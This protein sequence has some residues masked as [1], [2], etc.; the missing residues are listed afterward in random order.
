[1]TRLAYTVLVAAALAAPLAS[2]NRFVFDINSGASS[3]TFSGS[4]TLGPIQGNP[5][6]SFNPSGSIDLDL[7]TSGSTVTSGRFVSGATATVI[8]TLSA[9]VPN[10]ILPT[11]PPIATLTVTGA[12]VQFTSPS[13]SVTGGNFSTQVTATMLSGVASGSALGVPISIDLTG[14]QS[15]PAPISGTISHGANGFSLNVPLTGS[16]SFTEP[17]SGVGGTLTIAGTVVGD[18]AALSMDTATISLPS[19]GQQSLTLSAGSTH[20][21]GIYLVLG[22]GSGT[23]PGINLGGAT[24]PLN[25]DGWMTTSLVSANAPPFVNTVGALDTAGVA[26]AAIVFPPLA[27]PVLYGL[28]LDHAYLVL[29][30]TTPVFASNPVSL[31]LTP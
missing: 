14:N 3:F 13:F 7:Q 10:P 12:L 5:S 29:S 22:S 9:K 16:F 17:T 11:L 8:P 4:T 28:T 24:L 23:S 26:S 15:N 2:Q 30:G 18:D 21:S 27:I 6:N 19:G 25:F 31:T 20:A 1:M